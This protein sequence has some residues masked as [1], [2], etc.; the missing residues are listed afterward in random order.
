MSSVTSS[1]RDGCQLSGSVAVEIVG[2]QPDTVPVCAE[3]VFEPHRL[4]SS[5]MLG[6][7]ALTPGMKA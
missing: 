2:L 7:E 6:E 5:P 1:N 3:R 4:A